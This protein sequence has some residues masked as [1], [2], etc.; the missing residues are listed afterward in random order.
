MPLIA[1]VHSLPLEPELIERLARFKPALNA[2]APSSDATL[3]IGWFNTKP[4]AAAWAIGGND[5]RQLSGFAIH[6]ATVGR[7]VLA[8]LAICMRT[9]EN[10]AGRRVLS[11]E[12]YAALDVAV[13]TD[14]DK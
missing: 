7:D 6:P 8:Q 1:R 12:D 4:I 11:S 14:L 5:A 13:A 9:Q 2:K 10:A 3:Y